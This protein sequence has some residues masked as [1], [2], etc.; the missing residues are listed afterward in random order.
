MRFALYDVFCERRFAGNQAAV[1]RADA[2][3]PMEL[4]TDL[5]KEFNLP[6]TC[7]YWYQDGIPHVCFATSSGPIRA[8][9]HGLL[10]ALADTVRT[11][12]TRPAR[13]SDYIIEGF[14]SGKWTWEM[15]NERA[16]RIRAKWPNIPVFR[17]P[18]PVQGLTEFLRID[19]SDIALE[20]PLAAFDCGIVN[21]LVPIRDLGT[22]AQV[23]PDYGSAM[24]AY[25]DEHGLAD[26]E[27]YVMCQEG[28]DLQNETRI[29][30]RN[31]FPYGVREEPATGTASLSLATALYQAGRSLGPWFRMDQ[32]IS[33]QGKLLVKVDVENRVPIAIWIEG[34][35][36][37][38]VSGDNLTYP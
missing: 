26:L 9:G 24:T 17:K 36:H 18:L 25:F 23:H 33:R 14:G 38:V 28:N 12:E 32:G 30:T 19:A 2:P 22:L 13:E 16:T 27:L 4:L 5:A 6:E 31:I 21:G 15:L 7:V 20:L 8:C 34:Q 11:G 35:V 1:V 29:R 3:A 10:A 37:M